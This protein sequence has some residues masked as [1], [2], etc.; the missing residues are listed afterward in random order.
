[1]NKSTEQNDIIIALA[2]PYGKSAIAAI[3]IS[4]NGCIST[5]NA[6]LKHKLKPNVIAYNVFR[7]QNFTENL[8]A[9]CF[10]APNS[11]TG[12]DTVELYPHGNTAICDGIIKTLIDKGFRAAERGEFT[13]RA[14]INGKLDLM[15]CEALA[16]IIDAQTPEQLEYGNKRFN[17][18]FK[19]L[20]EAEKALE[21]ALSTVEAVLHYSDEL[22]AGEE[23]ES[24]GRDVYTAL[25][26]IIDRL[27]GEIDG[28]AGG[29]IIKDGFAVALLGVPNVGKSTLLNALVGSDRAIVT[30]IAGTTRDT[31]DGEYVYNGR[32]F[33]IIDTAG[34]T[35]TT[36]TVEKIGV[37]R[38]IKAAADAD[39]TVLVRTSD[40]ESQRD[41]PFK[42]TITVINKCDDADEKT[43]KRGE[44][45]KISAK[46]GKNIDALKQKLYDLCPK[47]VGGICDH[48]QYDCVKRCLDACVTARAELQKAQGLEIAAAALY[49][50]YS[51][52]LELYGEGGTADEKV[53]AA[54]FDRFCVG[55]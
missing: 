8:M 9:T 1:M 27:K 18:G 15:Q 33:R 34:I 32:K 16:D 45:I 26:G 43:L 47:T 23:E 40:K 30:P 6:C 48:R 22:E 5:V 44:E 31:I 25:D 3:R 12:E 24:L 51:A 10:S 36:D 37:E 53:I 28:Y 46:F 7:A 13:K 4:G 49:D 17:G 38:A 21:N 29:K 19:A 2:T 11:Y 39:A 55:K 50:A 20:G 52:I 41:F 42:P 14:F 35:E 54:V